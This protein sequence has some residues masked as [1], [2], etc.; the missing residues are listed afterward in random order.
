MDNDLDI[1]D[2]LLEVEAEATQILNEVMQELML[3][4]MKQA[5]RIRWMTMPDEAKEQVRDEY[6]EVYEQILL[7]VDPERS[8]Y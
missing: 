6:P 8:T 5:L 3:P 2:I 1:R 4:Q 7:M